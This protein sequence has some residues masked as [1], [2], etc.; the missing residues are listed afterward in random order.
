MAPGEL[1]LDLGL[2]PAQ[3]IEGPVELVLIDRPQTEDGAQRMRRARLAELA[4]GR[5]L[6]RRLEHTG[7]HQRQRQRRQPLGPARHQAVETELPGEAEHRGDM[8]VRQGPLDCQ[9][10][11]RRHHG[12]ALEHPAQ[13][14]D[15]GLGPAREIGQRAG[16][17][18]ATGAVALAQQD[19]FGTRVTYMRRLNHDQPPNARKHQQNTCLHIS[20]QIAP[21]SSSLNSLPENSA[22]SSV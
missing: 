9:L 17:D 18:L 5:E 14:L 15:L 16:P 1:R 13:R 22:G 8:T 21:F 12:F 11:A 2:R 6:G 3:Q 10:A 19:R 7:H 20:S 4:R